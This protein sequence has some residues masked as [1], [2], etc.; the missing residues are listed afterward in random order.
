MSKQQSTR[1]EFSPADG[2]RLL[3]TL[4]ADEYRAFNPGTTWNFNPWVGIRRN[5]ADIMSDPFGVLISVGDEPVYAAKPGD[6]NEATGEVPEEVKTAFAQTTVDVKLR[7]GEILYN[8][9]PTAVHWKHQQ[10]ALGATDAAPG[11]VGKPDHHI[12]HESGGGKLRGDHYYRVQI[13]DPI[14]PEVQP[15]A[16]ECAD[17]IEALGMTFNEGEAFK[18]IWRL[19]AARQGRGKPGNKAQYD[20]DKAAHYAARMAV[21]VKR[22]TKQ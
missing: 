3:A 1:F 6:W 16:A 5:G 20:A 10:H 19:A 17:I 22:E 4:T 11:E 7:N 18:A 2:R 9:P 21:C 15:Y 8:T 13:A 14:S 12:A